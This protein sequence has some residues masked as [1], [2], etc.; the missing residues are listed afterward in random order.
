MLL[1]IKSLIVMATMKTHKGRYYIRGL[2]I[3]AVH[4]VM[5]VI[6]IVNVMMI[7]MKHTQKKDK[8][9]C[10]NYCYYEPIV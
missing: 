10:R 8:R 9:S 2:A 1:V 3:I 4:I 7:M 6:T 5:L